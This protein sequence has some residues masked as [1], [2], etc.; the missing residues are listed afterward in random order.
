[1]V[2]TLHQAES[3]TEG[4]LYIRKITFKQ[5]FVQYNLPYLCQ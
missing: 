3:M 2:R 1:M 5:I 4:V